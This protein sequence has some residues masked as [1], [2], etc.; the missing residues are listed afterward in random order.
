MKHYIEV[1]TSNAYVIISALKMR[2]AVMEEMSFER[3]REF[4]DESYEI[5][6]NIREA[7]RNDG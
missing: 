4:I 3:Y 6:D 7:L 2:I 5:I 1:T